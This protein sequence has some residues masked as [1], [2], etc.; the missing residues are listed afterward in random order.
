MGEILLRIVEGARVALYRHDPKRHAENIPTR[1]DLFKYE[2]GYGW[3]YSGSGA[4]S[5]SFALAS[6]LSELERLSTEQLENRVRRILEYV[7]DKL[8]SEREHTITVYALRQLF[9]DENTPA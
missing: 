1:Y 4:K 6:K 7:V 8:D 5:L 3:G 9:T 2:G